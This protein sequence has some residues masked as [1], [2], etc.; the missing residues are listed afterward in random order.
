MLTVH[1]ISKSFILSP[2][3]T[4]VVFHPQPRRAAGA[5]R[6]ERLRQDHPAA[7]PGRA[8]ATRAGGFQFDPPGLRLGYLPQGLAPEPDDTLSSFLDRM[9]GDLPALGSPAGTAGGR[10]WRSTRQ[11]AGLQRH[12]TRRSARLQVRGCRAPAHRRRCWRR[13]AW[14]S[15]PSIRPVAHLS[16]GQKTRLALAGVLLS[17]AA[18]A[19]AGRADQPPGHRDAGMAGRLAGNAAYPTA[20]C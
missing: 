7:H 18:A 2:V 13:W 1:A 16:G 10:A 9:E 14:S 3:L 19:A 11:R 5:G 8:G 4:E 20:R 12:T 17:C 15:F 6:P